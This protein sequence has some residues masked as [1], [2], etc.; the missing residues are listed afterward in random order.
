MGGASCDLALVCSSDDDA[1]FVVARS[2]A[3]ITKVGVGA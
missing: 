1:P 2:R 3:T